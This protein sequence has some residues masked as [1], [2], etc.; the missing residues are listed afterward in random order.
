MMLWFGTVPTILRLS[1][2]LYTRIGALIKAHFIESLVTKEG[3][4]SKFLFG[5]A[6]IVAAIKTALLNKQL[7]LTIGLTAALTGGI[8]L[9]TYVLSSY[10][11]GRE[12]ARVEEEMEKLR[13][14]FGLTEYELTGGSLID[15]IRE[16]TRAYSELYNVIN[17]D[18]RPGFNQVEPGV[19]IR[20]LSI[21][22]IV[23]NATVREEGDIDKIK[24]AVLEAIREGTAR[25]GGYSY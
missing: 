7:L 6:S 11:L 21:G 15:S 1:S 14:E 5:K 18:F 4:L 20:A 2:E 22:N 23:V 8:M 24:L 13:E 25:R 19:N 9:L 17:R 10:F 3:A 16:T 12:L